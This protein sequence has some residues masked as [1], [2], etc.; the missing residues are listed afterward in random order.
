[1]YTHISTLNFFMPLKLKANTSQD[2]CL[3][4][5]NK[6]LQVAVIARAN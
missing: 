2:K 4:I 6:P 3:D 1:M 5:L